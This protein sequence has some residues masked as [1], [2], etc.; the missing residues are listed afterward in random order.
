MFI[1]IIGTNHEHQYLRPE[2]DSSNFE[3]YIR[4]VL[5]EKDFDLVE[6][7]MSEESIACV[8]AIGSVAKKVAIEEKIEHLFCDPESKERAELGIRSERDIIRELSGGSVL[9]PKHKRA[10]QAQIE[11]G[12]AIRERVWLDRVLKTGIHS[13]LFVCGTPH[14]KRFKKLLKEKQAVD[15]PLRKADGGVCD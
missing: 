11:I 9:H 4:D 14:V 13:I 7:E 15:E 10:F 6:E 2:K 12:W 8:K 3:F 5:R 1:K